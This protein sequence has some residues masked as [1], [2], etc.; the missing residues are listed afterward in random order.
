[1]QLNRVCLK[2][3]N[4]FYC[5]FNRIYYDSI[6]RRINPFIGSVIRIT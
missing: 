3:F 4:F 5:F 6:Y 2:F 1:M